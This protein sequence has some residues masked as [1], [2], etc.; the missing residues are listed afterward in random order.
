MADENKVTRGDTNTGGGPGGGIT[1]MAEQGWLAHIIRFIVAAIVLMVVSYITPGFTRL[2][3]WHALLAAVLV[4]A[5]GFGL[6]TL[7]G[8]RISPYARWGRVCGL[9]GDLLLTPV[10]Y[11]WFKG[12]CT[13]SSHSCCYRRHYRYVCANGCTLIKTQSK[14]PVSI[15][16]GVCIGRWW[17]VVGK[18]MFGRARAGGTGATKLGRDT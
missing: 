11:P 13:G 18:R 14:N 6:E 10:H 4:A 3:F 12:D 8:R 15:G 7:F 9:S 2:S 5:I 16:G 1:G 17:L